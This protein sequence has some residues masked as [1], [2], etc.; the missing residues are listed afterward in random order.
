MTYLII[1]HGSD[2]DDWRPYGDVFHQPGG[3][4]WLCEDRWVGVGRYHVDTQ[5]GCVK[6]G[7]VVHLGGLKRQ[8]QRFNEIKE[9]IGSL[10]PLSRT[11]R[12]INE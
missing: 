10:D 2:F 4:Q 3:V 12:L 11:E 5:K 9:I 7:R 8:D 1:V 6:P